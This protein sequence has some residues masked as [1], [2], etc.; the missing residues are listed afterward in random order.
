MKPDDLSCPLGIDLVELKKARRFYLSS[1]RDL[2]NYFTPG[3]V[4]FMRKHHRPHEALAEI[5][6]G[7]E[8]LFKALPASGRMGFEGLRTIRIVPKKTHWDFRVPRS[9]AAFLKKTRLSIHRHKHYV[10]ALVQPCVGIS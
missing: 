6:A 5:L 7:K 4:R 9:S 1:R 8:A 10:V 3:E 2:E